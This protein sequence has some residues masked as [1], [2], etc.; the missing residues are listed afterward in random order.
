MPSKRFLVAP[1]DGGLVNNVT[2]WLIPDKAFEKL[3]NMYVFRGRLRKRF[4][5]DLMHNDAN[6]YDETT[7]QLGSRLRINIGTTAAVSGNFTSATPAV[8]GG[9]FKQG[10]MFSVDETMF[11]VIDDTP[12]AQATLTT[13]AATAT[14]DVSTGTLIITGNTENPSTAVYFYPSEPV[15][16]IIQNESAAIND[17]PTYA[18]DTR[19][20]YQY[21]A[22]AWERLGTSPGVWTGNND[23]FFWATSWR[24]GTSADT[25]FFTTNFSFGNDTSDSDPI[26]Y[27]NGATWTD[28]TPQFNSTATNLILT[29]RIILPFK[30]RLILL[31]VIENTG[32][33]VGTNIQYGNRCR[34]SQNGDPSA[35]ATS[36][37]EDV[38]GRGGYIDAPTQEQ[39][40]SAEFL[41]DRLIVFFEQSTWE[42][43]YTG[44]EILPFRWQKI[45]TELGVE[46]TFSIVPFDQI[47]MG[48]GNAG[49]HA[50]SGASVQRIDS[51][52][53]DFVF[54]FANEN[55]GVKRVQGIRD[56]FV[57]QVYWSFPA[58]G[59][60]D[61]VFPNMVLVYDYKNG[62]WAIND[63]SI[64]SFGYF[65]NQSDRTWESSPESWQEADF[66]WSSPTIISKFRHVLAGN[67]QGFLFI[68]DSED[69]RNAPALQITQVSGVN[70]E[71]LEVID[72]NLKV[73]D[74]IS[75]WTV[76]GMTYTADIVRVLLVT[77]ADNITIDTAGTGTYTGGGTI[78]RVSQPEMLTKQ[79]NF[80][81]QAGVNMS[82]D[83]VD[84]LVDKTVNGEFLSQSLASSSNVV[85]EEFTVETK[86]YDINL[87]PLEQSQTRLWH[88]IYPSVNG[89]T[90]QFNL[91]FSDAQMRDVN[92]VSSELQIHAFMFYVQSTSSRFE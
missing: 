39:I 11:T 63:D 49:I 87:Y 70:N 5:S 16:G 56:Y 74:Y 68:L 64:T 52:I 73:D 18:F 12:G 54:G 53:P 14:F 2:S 85:I 66:P 6:P 31:N 60:T 69:T 80:F 32:G 90:A 55:E 35:P 62:T 79:Y 71:D 46:S 88:S 92:I 13:G 19:F 58:G 75:L 72:H 43:V 36:F 10:Q 59:E 47:V 3:Q 28:Y 44:N 61:T 42:L 30:D 89:E 57:E 9:L 22:G 67:Q 77:D 45:N 38:G 1:L 84:F 48:V 29:S 17:E 7:A 50:C 25:L 78:G 82:V 8:T 20:A 40:I 24:G 76:N 81:N 51:K 34:F 83:Q 23:D 65:Q 26:K 21:T 91:T 27:W 33:G 41:K 4:G 86:P 15:M 37:L